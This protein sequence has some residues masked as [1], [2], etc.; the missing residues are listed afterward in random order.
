[1]TTADDCAVQ[2]GEEVLALSVQTRC[3]FSQLN[4]TDEA[5]SEDTLLYQ[6]ISL[7]RSLLFLWT[8]V[9]FL[10][11]NCPLRCAEFDIPCGGASLFW[12]SASWQLYM[13]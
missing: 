11:A 10:S 5:L 13:L 3:P 7:F 4:G 6:F 12:H 2:S 8:A 9:T 1:V